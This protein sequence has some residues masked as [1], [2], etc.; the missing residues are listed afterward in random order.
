L[1]DSKIRI[2]LLE[3]NPADRCLIGAFL[4]EAN[5]FRFV[6][7]GVDRVAE[8]LRSLNRSEFDLVLLDLSLPDA[9]GL[10]GFERIRRAAPGVPVIVLTGL[11]DDASA[12]AA[13]NAGAQDYLVK[14]RVDGR[15]LIRSM[16]YA[17]ERH[18]VVARLHQ[19]LEREQEVAERLR[20][21]QRRF[22]SLVASMPG[23]VYR[24]EA[25]APWTCD[26]MSEAVSAITGYEAED[27]VKGRW[28]WQDIV[29][30]EDAQV[31]KE[32]L[33]ESIDQGTSY[34][35][36]YRI[37]RAHGETRWVVDRGMPVYSDDGA[38]RFLEGVVFDATRQKHAEEAL[39]RLRIL[40]DRERIARELHD[41]VIQSLFALG[42][43]LQAAAGGADTNGTAAALFGQAVGELDQII[44]DVRGYIFALR[45][46]LLGGI[47]LE[48]DLR[49]V[50]RAFEVSKVRVTVKVDP[51]AARAMAERGGGE[52]LVQAS[53]EALSNA[54]RHSGCRS[55]SLV[56]RLDDGC[57]VLRITD[58]GKGFASAT[59]AAGHG[60]ANLEARARSLGGTLH[61]DSSPESGTSVA[62]TIPPAPITGESPQ[63]RARNGGSTGDPRSRARSG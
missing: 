49:S 30:P 19:S 5:G 22:R 8:G 43:R 10:E 7:E 6:L 2:L 62:L 1:G 16:R 46:S 53:R 33:R 58:D 9:S 11:D 59:S 52:H 26:F 47:E 48:R 14:G 40:E 17:I 57:V 21:S 12:V 50:A 34:R 38:M 32:G 45:P 23:A 56:L 4:R 24:R 54:V 29:H 55:V 42:S 36:E 63:R 25:Q 51:A 18:Q 35:I 28:Q 13:V 3:D 60:L 31:V 15:V 27:F 44:R 61:I 20:E 37:V 41:G 39:E